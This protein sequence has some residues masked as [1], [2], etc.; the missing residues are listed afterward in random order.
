VSFL[1]PGG[2]GSEQILCLCFSEYSDRKAF[3]PRPAR[4]HSHFRCV[5]MC[6]GYIG[7]CVCMYMGCMD[8]CVYVYWVC[9]HVHVCICMGCVDM[10]VS[11][12]MGCVGMCVRMGCGT[13]V[14]VHVWGVYGCIWGVW[15]CVCMYK[16]CRHVCVC[17]WSV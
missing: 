7:M 9:G 6:M 4:I 14:Y 2:V 15:V 12:C 5:C 1:S 3:D 13:C 17:V 10:C 11:I 8:M 16:V